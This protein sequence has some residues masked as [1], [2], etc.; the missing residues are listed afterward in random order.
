VRFLLGAAQPLDP[1]PLELPHAAWQ[2]HPCRLVCAPQAC[3][4]RAASPA[5]GTSCR[6]SSRRSRRVRARLRCPAAACAPCLLPAHACRDAEAGGACRAAGLC[7]RV[8]VL[9]HRA[10]QRAPPP[11]PPPQ[12]CLRSA[13]HTRRA[14][15]PSCLLRG[16][17]FFDDCRDTEGSSSAKCLAET[18]GCCRA[19]LLRL[20]PL[21]RWVLAADHR[22]AAG[23]G[24]AVPEWEGRAARVAVDLHRCAG[25][26]GV[27]SSRAVLAHRQCRA[28][29]GSRAAA[30]PT[31]EAAVLPALRA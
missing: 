22:R 27:A 25:A 10:Q 7:V 9:Q 20:T 18:T 13:E 14:V 21:A 5:A 6:S 26:L 3:L 29:L 1:S 19:F 30:P 23:G 8:R 28:K 31:C 15:C 24:A 2:R 4:R 17:R 16:L 11:R 12:Q